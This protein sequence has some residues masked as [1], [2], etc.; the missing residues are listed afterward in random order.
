M[1]HH[2]QP[3]L[4]NKTDIIWDWNGTLIDDRKLCVEVINSIL[5]EEELPTLTME[6]YRTTFR[7]PIVEYYKT[8]GLRTEPEAFKR[9]AVAFTER[10]R[11]RV[12][13]CRLYPHVIDLLQSFGELNLRQS[14]L[15]A[16][17]ENHLKVLLRHFKIDHHFDQVF[18]LEDHYAASKIERGR[19]LLQKLNVAKE[20]ILLIGDTDHDAEV[21]RVLDI[22]VVLIADGHQTPER[23]KSAHSQVIEK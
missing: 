9:L 12:R 15:S 5:E 18:A 21:G 22:D 17:K 7:F 13:D 4:K 14:I 8:L 23:L 11:A 20:T 6:Q 2:L 3:H 16:A 19:Q 1:K 10:Y